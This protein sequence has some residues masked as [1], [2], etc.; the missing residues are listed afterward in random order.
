MKNKKSLIYL[1][2]FILCLNARLIAAQENL[3]QEKLTQKDPETM[4]TRS[5][6]NFIPTNAPGTALTKLEF[7]KTVFDN[8]KRN[9]F[10]GA[11]NIP[12]TD[13]TNSSNQ[14]SVTR[15]FNDVRPK[16]KGIT[17]QKISV[18]NEDGSGYTEEPNDLY[19]KII[20][21]L[22]LFNKSFPLVSYQQ[23]STDPTKANDSNI[24]YLIN[25]YNDGKLNIKTEA[26][27]DSTP[28]ETKQI[29]A[30]AGSD[31]YAFAVVSATGQDWESNAPEGEPRGIAVV[32][33]TL[34]VKIPTIKQIA[35]TDL[36]NDKAEAT[37][38]N[39]DVKKAAKL[40]SF[41]DAQ[42]PAVAPDKEPI[43]KAYINPDVNRLD[44]DVD[45]Y[46]DNG[47]SR[48][49]IGLSGIHRDDQNKEGGCFSVIVGR[50]VVD[51]TSG[52]DKA[53]SLSP[54]LSS[55]T[56]AKL[57]DETYKNSNAFMVG[58]YFDGRDDSDPKGN[59][60][61]TISAKKVRVMHTSTGKNY[62]IANCN[63][64]V[65]ETYN[66]VFALPILGS[67]TSD[68]KTAIIEEQIGTLS[69][70]GNDGLPTFDSIPTNAAEMPNFDVKDQTQTTNGIVV[71]QQE[72]PLST[73][74]LTDLFVHG[75][76]VLICLN[77]AGNVQNSG[78]FQS[79]A[80]FNETGKIIDWTPWQRVMGGEQRVYGGNVDNLS[81]F[82][83]LAGDAADT[84]KPNT[85]RMTLWGPTNDVNLSENIVNGTPIFTNEIPTR[86]LSSLLSSIF[87]QSQGGV[88]QII[89]F[90][91]M[92]PGFN[93]DFSMMVAVG[94]D[95][96][97]LIQTLEKNSA[98]EFVS[99]KHFSDSGADQNV[100]VFKNDPVLNEIAPLCFA[101]VSRNTDDNSGWLF[102]GG[103]NGV[104]V[105]SKDDGTGWASQGNGLYRLSS[106]DFPGTGYS[107]KKLVPGNGGDF[108][109][110]RKL[111]SLVS[112]DKKKLFIQTKDNLYAIDQMAAQFTTGDVNET[113]FFKDALPSTLKFTDLLIIP[114]ADPTPVTRVL[115]AAN[116]FK[117]ILGS[118]YGLITGKYNSGN[119]SITF[120]G[121]GS[122]TSD[123]I[124]H[125]NYISKTK[126][127]NSVTGN[128]YAL[129]ANFLTN[130]GK[131]YRYSVDG[132]NATP[133]TKIITDPSPFIDFF[134]FRGDFVTDGAFGFS[135][136]AK[137]PSDNFMTDIY[138]ITQ[139]QTETGSID[140]LLEQNNTNW[141][142]GVITRNTA[143]GSWLVPGDWGV[144]VNE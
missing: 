55:P 74:N 132:S 2:A 33:P 60:D 143:S 46:W 105:L 68:G 80:L 51:P 133:L 47:L 58:F 116:N 139:T 142:I 81:N 44:A 56:K 122:S 41:S 50:I 13:A 1:T 24:L 40:I 17:P 66:K 63:V 140:E 110:V 87:P 65:D 82:Y 135:M 115:P 53:L 100:F 49:F 8:T 93:P 104:A 27:K 73:E 134:N 83:F 11:K 12:S 144:R 76:S 94:Y 91:E 86:N 78:I 4:Q 117:F 31:Y 28:A 84:T 75:D 109:N 5:I 85:I 141:Y 37:A 119:D 15:T 52:K 89:N 3:E 123:P 62:L 103:Y 96:I 127:L 25:A 42:T 98:G 26:L 16:I 120:S 108:N 97:A 35:A 112:S 61:I 19:G 54:I 9:F 107:F 36:S 43:A 34:N 10:L 22:G 38:L 95:K 7:N 111:A 21:N 124:L 30:L 126:G 129:S 118:T 88:F 121:L 101:E 32:K 64:T 29:K 77:D 72:S 131:I 114:T 57:Y 14:Y 67:K 137:G 20:L 90:D 71:G 39:V 45:M 48:L 125:L 6:E 102:V 70:I 136:I 79:T 113:K 23:D 130:S 106:E 138:Q 92:T 128:L 99:V 69:K 18:P 59:T